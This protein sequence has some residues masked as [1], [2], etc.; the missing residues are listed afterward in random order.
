MC[1]ECQ[2]VECDMC[3]EK[4]LQYEVT[5]DGEWICED[6]IPKCEPKIFQKY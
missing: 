3:Y 4:T 2:M 6:C 1:A 5:H